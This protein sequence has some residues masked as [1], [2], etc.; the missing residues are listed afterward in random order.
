MDNNEDIRF[1][2][3]LKRNNFKLVEI[4]KLSS[5]QLRINRLFQVKL[6][7]SLD[8][9]TIQNESQVVE[10]GKQIFELF[11]VF[12]NEPQNSIFTLESP[13]ALVKKFPIDSN[14]LENDLIDQVDW[15]VKQFSFSYDDEYIVD[16]QQ[17]NSSDEKPIKEIIVVSVR[18]KII[19]QLKK[20]FSA[21]KMHLNVIDLDVF[22]AIRAIENNYDL[23]VGELIALIEIDNKGLQ[24]TILKDKN[25]FLSQEVFVF[26][27]GNDEE[28]LAAI[29]D[30]EIARVISRELKRIIQDHHLGE[31][32]ECLNRIF[33]YGDFVRDNILENL[34]NNFNVRIEKTNPFR[35]LFIGPK[36]STDERISSH[37]ETF[38]VCVGS[39]L[40]TKD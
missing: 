31:N 1:G 34:Q 20:L 16:F 26:K 35:N 10:I 38:T 21:A 11:N 3:Y 2:I 28:N 6:D 27:S 13:F 4:E 7:S 22:A 8:V 24:F 15:E 17:L 19:Q 33:L 12:N 9:K 36:V 25:F 5:G 32:I 40:R 18:E 29:D 23:R 39:A 14:I 30:I 37:P